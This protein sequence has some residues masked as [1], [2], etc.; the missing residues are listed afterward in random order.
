MR[1]LMDSKM[2]VWD[3]TSVINPDMGRRRQ[4]FGV[5]RTLRRQQPYTVWWDGTIIGFRSTFIEAVRV[6]QREQIESNGGSRERV[7]FRELAA[8]DW[9]NMPAVSVPRLRVHRHSTV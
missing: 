5:V 8:H 3:K 1:R 2:M 6:Y 7:T 4:L 9:S